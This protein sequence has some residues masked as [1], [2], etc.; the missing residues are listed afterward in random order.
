[1]N[2]KTV[3]L[4]VQ[5]LVNG[6]IA[7]NSNLIRSISGDD[8]LVIFKEKND[9]HSDFYFKLIKVSL[10]KGK[11]IYNIDY[12]PC[13]STHLRPSGGMLC[14]ITALG[15]HLKRWINL[16]EEYNQPSPIFDDPITKKYYEDLAPRFKIV[17]EDAEYV[18]F[19][20]EQQGLMLEIYENTKKL[21]RD[22]E[23]DENR[24]EAQAIIAEIN[25]AEKNVSKDTKSKAINRLRKI[26]AMCWKYSYTVAKAIMAEVIVEVGK[27]LLTSGH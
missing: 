25:N 13:D 10:E 14:E 7:E 3:P 23:D 8:S 15:E 6:L 18:P 20:F 24:E 11:T 16:L 26:V 19:R 5:Q 21:V 1:M 4:A 22:N 17:D 2:K 12:L 27:R 9:E